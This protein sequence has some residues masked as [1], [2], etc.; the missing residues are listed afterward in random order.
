L[1]TTITSRGKLVGKLTLDGG[2]RI[3]QELVVRAT[4]VDDETVFD[5]V[6]VTVAPTGPYFTWEPSKVE[7]APRD[8]FGI[9]LANPNIK[10]P[11]YGYLRGYDYEDL[12]IRLRVG[13]LEEGVDY[14]VT[15]ENGVSGVR[16]GKLVLT[17][18]GDPYEAVRVDLNTDAITLLDP[19]KTG[20]VR[21]TM[22]RGAFFGDDVNDPGFDPGRTSL[23]FEV[24][25]NRAVEEIVNLEIDFEGADTRPVQGRTA[26][27]GVHSGGNPVLTAAAHAGTATKP[28][29]ISVNWNYLSYRDKFEKR[30]G[31]DGKEIPLVATVILHAPADQ[32]FLEAFETDT[33]RISNANAF[34]YGIP[35]VI[36]AEVSENGKI[37]EFDLEY[38]IYAL[39]LGLGTTG[40]IDVPLN[41]LLSP[42]NTFG[43]RDIF[44]ATV[45]PVHTTPLLKELD[46]QVNNYYTA[47]IKWSGSGVDAEKG[48][49]KSARGT[50][51]P[52]AVATI[53]LQPKPG[54]TFEGTN[55]LEGHLVKSGN[56]NYAFS[57]GFPTGVVTKGEGGALVLT[58]TYSV[59]EKQITREDLKPSYLEKLIARPIDG[60]PVGIKETE[61]ED[62]KAVDASP[63]TVHLVRWD[64]TTRSVNNYRFVKGTVVTADITLT[65]KEGF[66][67]YQVPTYW[68]D[69]LS[70]SA[71]TEAVAIEAHGTTGGTAS[72]DYYTL[73]YQ[74][75]YNG[76]AK[77]LRQITGLNGVS[78]DLIN[79]IHDVQAS[80]V[81]GLYP[82]NPAFAAT[83]SISWEGTVWDAVANQWKWKYGATTRALIKIEA[84]PG[85]TFKH[86]ERVG[87]TYFSDENGK[88]IIEGFFATDVYS[89]KK[90]EEGEVKVVNGP[91]ANGDHIE[92]TLQY[93]VKP[94]M[95][96]I[97][98]LTY[99][100]LGWWQPTDSVSTGGV[101]P[102][103]FT[104]GSGGNFSAK[105]LQWKAVDINDDTLYDFDDVDDQ[106]DGTTSRFLN[107]THYQARLILVPASGY[108]FDPDLT[109]TG[110]NEFETY[111]MNGSNAAPWGNPSANVN[112]ASNLLNIDV[113]IPDTG[114]DED[115]LVITLTF[116]AT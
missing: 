22:L 104:N 23:V 6:T 2:L 50:P 111:H 67:F 29:F 18:I 100:E 97:T 24:A 40:G 48:V 107:N 77:V 65:A 83:S 62:F 38:E 25:D 85:Y 47:D 92:F 42:V 49:L 13:V 63:Y 53:T 28:S 66:V 78:N 103:G 20:I 98:A 21:I 58:I 41:T 39:V 94:K 79:P 30:V 87:D 74:V 90:G 91:Y 69:P 43:L 5:E 33:T 80:H 31:E 55:I 99:A 70:L 96:D 19:T 57:Y 106:P 93:T 54:Y 7:A 105:R 61:A 44:S 37:L 75:N 52:K 72:A 36:R 3:G 27:K 108:Y 86:H 59:T 60:K 26:P 68:T 95:I 51:K 8:N 34:N 56:T 64:P 10:V 9:D 82:T 14:A 45:L 1:S 17:G 4:A 32:Y 46:Y 101:I 73:D 84:A 88:T 113:A 15:Y 35:K 16:N 89:D 102:I 114:D 115:N 116:K 109:T 112:S 110:G 76:G 71:V 12:D 81:T 11:P